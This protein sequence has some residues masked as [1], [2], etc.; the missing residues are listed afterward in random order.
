MN[1]TKKRLA[2]R[3]ELVDNNDALIFI[4]SNQSFSS[5]VDNSTVAATIDREIGFNNYDIGHNFNT[6]GGGYAGIGQVCKD[7]RSSSYQS[8]NHKGWGSSGASDPTNLDYF[9][10]NVLAKMVHQFY[11]WHTMNCNLS[12]NNSEVEP[13]GG[14]TVMAYGDFCSPAVQN[15][16]DDYFHYNSLESIGGFLKNPFGANCSNIIPVTNE[17]PTVDAGSDYTIPANT[18]FYLTGLGMTQRQVQVRVGLH[19]L[20]HGNRTMCKAIPQIIVVTHNP[21]G[22]MDHYTVLP[23]LL[24]PTR[25]FQHSKLFWRV[26]YPQRGRSPLRSREN[27]ILLLQPETI[28]VEILG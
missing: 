19:L 26:V 1:Y 23:H 7:N 3:L 14:T 21:H 6:S 9:V 24:S 15:F 28:V 18:A 17:P 22:L 11:G 12:G 13:G 8:G 2:V 4:P 25:Y 5:G 16:T 20:T 10:L 27:L